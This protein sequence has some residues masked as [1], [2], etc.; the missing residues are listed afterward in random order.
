MLILNQEFILMKKFYL[1]IIM[2]GLFT[3]INFSIKAQT[4]I[5]EKTPVPANNNQG[6]SFFSA[7]YGMGNLWQLYLK[8]SGEQYD[9]CSFKSIGPIFGKYEYFITNKIGFGM[10]FSYVSANLN[11]TDTSQVIQ[12]NPLIFYQEQI[13]WYSYSILLRFN[14]HF[15][16]M[17]NRFDPYLGFGMGYRLSNWIYTDN[18]P[19]YNHDDSH[20]ALIPLGME[21]TMG[22]RF[23]ITNFLGVYT[24]VGLAKAVIQVGVVSRF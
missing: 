20:S 8:I 14:W 21:F 24:E 13:D 16:E 17:G 2:V 4:F 7:G 18:D 9:N 22:M 23:M 15:S 5:Q 6:R 10:V 12:K 1:L 19:S 3:T 11:Y